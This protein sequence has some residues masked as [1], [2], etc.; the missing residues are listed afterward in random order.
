[1][2]VA[3]LKSI[4]LVPTSAAKRLATCDGNGKIPSLPAARFS[5][6]CAVAVLL[7]LDRAL[8]LFIFIHR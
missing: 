5:C 1:M 8:Q 4:S 6:F 3:L 7:I 2:F